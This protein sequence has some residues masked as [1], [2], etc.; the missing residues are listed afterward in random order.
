MFEIFKIRARS[1]DSSTPQEG[2]CCFRQKEPESVHSNRKY[3]PRPCLILFFPFVS[4]VSSSLLSFSFLSFEHLLGIS[5]REAIQ[6]LIVCL[7]QMYY[8]QH[9]NH[10]I[11]K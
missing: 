1:S 5:L 4:F 3:S 9:G 2:G 11:N 10:P 7:V 6:L 8:S